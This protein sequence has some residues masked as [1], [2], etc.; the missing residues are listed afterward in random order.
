MS[1]DPGLIPNTTRKQFLIFQSLLIEN[2]TGQKTNILIAFDLLKATSNFKHP[3]A[4]KKPVRDGSAR[5][6]NP[7]PPKRREAE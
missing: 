3:V 5:G 7:S 1:K 2:T 6:I 4:Q